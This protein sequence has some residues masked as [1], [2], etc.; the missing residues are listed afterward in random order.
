MKR[1]FFLLTA[2]VAATLAIFIFMKSGQEKREVSQEAS[3]PRVPAAQ[4]SVPAA[5]DS[6][7][8]VTDSQSDKLTKA[9]ANNS[10]TEIKPLLSYRE[11]TKAI[12]EL[13]SRLPQSKPILLEMIEKEDVFKN[14]KT[15]LK[16]HSIDEITQNQLGAIKV[17]ALRALIKAEKD[18]DQI[19]QDIDHIIQAAKDPT[20][21]KIAQAARDS[22]DKGGHFPDDL[23]NG[24]DQ[25]PLKK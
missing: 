25:M 1:G 19:K 10:E 3:L 5:V 11:E 20:I 9:V 24:I 6:A 14:P 2:L 4:P 18:P 15:H 12:A 7:A 13:V 17:M 22:I 21:V 8:R 16:E 23:L